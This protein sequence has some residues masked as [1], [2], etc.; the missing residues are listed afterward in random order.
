LF[1]CACAAFA[2]GAEVLFLLT[3]YAPEGQQ[4]DYSIAP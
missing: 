3:A 1:V 4:E 2:G